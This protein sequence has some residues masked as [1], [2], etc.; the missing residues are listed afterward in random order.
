MEFPEMRLLQFLLLV[1]V[2]TCAVVGGHSRQRAGCGYRFFRFPATDLR[3]R[4]LWLAA[5][6]RQ[7]S[8][9]KQWSPG[10]GDRVCSKHFHGG[11]PSIDPA[12]E[13]YTPSLQLGHTDDGSSSESTGRRSRVRFQ[14]RFNRQVRGEEQRE[15]KRALSQRLE[16]EVRSV[17]RNHGDYVRSGLTDS[18]DEPPGKRARQHSGMSQLLC[19][20]DNPTI[21]AEVGEYYHCN[22]HVC[23]RC[24]CVS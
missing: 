5:L 24:V 17:G 3:R 21:S 8:D 22:K 13:D 7:R 10:P 14:R 23:A 16:C 12:H 20:G 9:G 1:A 2:T 15:K 11:E 19:A 4:R 18:D 6:R